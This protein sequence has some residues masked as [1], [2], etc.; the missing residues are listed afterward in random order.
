MTL[1]MQ[2][3]LVEGAR[4]CERTFVKTRSAVGLHGGSPREREQAPAGALE[5]DQPA[6]EAGNTECRAAEHLH[7]TAASRLPRVSL[8]RAQ[9]GAVK[10]STRLLVQVGRAR[11]AGRG[12]T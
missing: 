12:T 8:R 5:G 9:S 4:H 3:T 7:A 1:S 6:L 10:Q 2:R 11:S